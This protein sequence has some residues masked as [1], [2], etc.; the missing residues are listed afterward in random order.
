[1]RGGRGGGRGK[2]KKKG[3]RFSLSIPPFLFLPNFNFS[4]FFSCVSS[5]RA[6]YWG[7]R[8]TD[9]LA[10]GVGDWLPVGVYRALRTS[11]RCPITAIALQR[12]VRFDDHRI[13]PPCT[14]RTKSSL[15]FHLPSG[16]E[17]FPP[18]PNR[19]ATQPEGWP[20]GPS[21]SPDEPA[22]ASRPRCRAKEG[23]ML[24][25]WPSQGSGGRRDLL[26]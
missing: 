9:F 1:M 18:D 20:R 25:R 5:V 26:R 24:A 15:P 14:A 13:Q 2:G 7:T 8:G 4:S 10:V 12:L 17:R 22:P 6:R 23:A 11:A 19:L 16:E 3:T 21:R